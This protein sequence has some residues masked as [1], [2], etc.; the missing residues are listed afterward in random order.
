MRGILQAGGECS[1]LISRSK[2]VDIAH[3]KTNNISFISSLKYN[4]GIDSFSIHLKRLL[5]S[6]PLNIT[7]PYGCFFS[8][9][10]KQSVVILL[11]SVNVTENDFSIESV[12]NL[13]FKINMLI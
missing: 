10:I 12:S 6:A 11:K 3:Q 13:Y 5:L 7:K 9:L 2:S 1:I 8:Q 4:A